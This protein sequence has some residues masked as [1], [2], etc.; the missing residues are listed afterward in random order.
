MKRLLNV[1][2]FSEKA[3]KSYLDFTQGLRT[4]DSKASPLVLLILYSD[5]CHII[6]SLSRQRKKTLILVIFS[7]YFC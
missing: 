3:V 6:F 1:R 7:S 2:A 4:I 5:T